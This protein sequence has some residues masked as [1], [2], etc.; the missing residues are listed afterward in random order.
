V[1]EGSSE[2]PSDGLPDVWTQLDRRDNEQTAGADHP[3]GTFPVS[4]S[5][6]YR[7]IRLRQTGKNANGSDYLILFALEI[8][9]ELLE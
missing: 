4:A 3:I 5:G 8:F 2:S 9:G 1:I 6:E 7:F